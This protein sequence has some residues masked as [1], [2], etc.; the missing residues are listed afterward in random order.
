V[1][2]WRHWQRR[3]ASSCRFRNFVNDSLSVVSISDV[4]LR[5]VQPNH[6]VRDPKA[7][8]GIR[9]SAAAFVDDRDGSSMSVYVRSL[10]H[11][12]DLQDSSV[13][14]GKPSRWGVAAIPVETLEQEAQR[15]ELNPVV[16]PPV[17]HLCDPAHAL[18]HGDKQQKARRDRLSRASPLSYIVP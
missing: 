2:T 1:S 17:S 4:A 18:V 11:A 5:R 10:V 9:A 14:H 15:L 3:L 7:P 12:L 8:D 6:V 16:D 13:V